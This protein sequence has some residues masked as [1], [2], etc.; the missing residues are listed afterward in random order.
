[1]A[2]WRDLPGCFRRSRYPACCPMPGALL[3]V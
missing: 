1:L 3:G 2:L